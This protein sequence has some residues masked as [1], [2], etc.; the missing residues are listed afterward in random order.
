MKANKS[1]IMKQAWTLFR[2]YNINFGQ[3][4]KKSWTDFKRQ[5]YVAVYNSIP[6]KPSLAKKKLEAK[7]M[8]ESFNTVGFNLTLRVIE[9]NSGAKNYYDGKTLNLD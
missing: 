1:T 4:L 8:Y 6:S 9:N 5:F 2:K 7:K 3:A